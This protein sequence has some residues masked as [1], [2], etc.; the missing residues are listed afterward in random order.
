M[1]IHV[2]VV[3]MGNYLYFCGHLKCEIYCFFLRFKG[4]ELYVHCV[5]YSTEGDSY[6][7]FTMIQ[8]RGIAIE[9]RYG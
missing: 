1:C 6:K 2:P 3:Y 7:A 9:L 8:E 4:Q 5:F